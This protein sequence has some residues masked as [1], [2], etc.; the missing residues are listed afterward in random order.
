MSEIIFPGPEGRLEGKFHKNEN[1]NAPA[2]LI[3]HPHPRHGEEGARV[4]L[5]PPQQAGLRR[6]VAGGG[7]R[8]EPRRG[9]DPQRPRVQ[10]RDA[11]PQDP[12][13]GRGSHR[14]RSRQSR[15]ANLESGEGERP[16]RSAW[17]SAPALT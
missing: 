17:T 9:Q 6:Q 5:R 1:K 10:V 7:R 2:A 12:H 4:R 11:Q 13:G 16:D 8:P 3:L 14:R 15:T